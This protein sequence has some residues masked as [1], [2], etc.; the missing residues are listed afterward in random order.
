MRAKERIP[1]R[2]GPFA[3]G[4]KI[5]G[6][7]MASVHLGRSVIAPTESPIVALKIVK[8]ELARDRRYIDMFRDEA[9]IL[10][11]MSHPHIVRTLEFGVTG[12][13]RYIAMELLLGRTVAEMWE[14]CEAQGKHFASPL[15]AWLGARIA[16]ALHYA[17]T[18]TD[19]HGAPLHVVHRDAN[20]ANVVVCDDGDVKLID[21]GLA[22]SAKRFAR[23]EDGI[24]KGKVPYLAPEQIVEEEVDGRSDVFALGASLWE[25]LAMRR[26]FKRDTD[27]DTIRAIRDLAVPP[28]PGEPEVPAALSAIVM[29]CLAPSPNDRFATAREVEEALDAVF[30]RDDAA[31]RSALADLLHELFPEDRTARATWTT[32]LHD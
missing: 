15:V 4:R 20:P 17:H 2:L 3:V 30:G 26:L 14:A 32:R 21:F 10:S 7:G 22:K 1:T 29:R 8:S 9:S 25:L 16:S 27:L 19:E 6:G 18:L 5:G 28:L 12:H 23:T 31:S 24:V 11:R 13:H